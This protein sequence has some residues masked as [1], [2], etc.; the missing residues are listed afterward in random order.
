MPKLDFVLTWDWEY[1]SWFVNRFA[2]ACQVAAVDSLFVGP[3]NLKQVL[4]RIN[5]QE[6]RFRVLLDRASDTEEAFDPLIDQIVLS[7]TTNLNK[8]SHAVKAMDKA[9]M[10]L[11][12]LSGGIDVPHTVIISDKDNLSEFRTLE[13]EKLGIP[14]IVK[15]ATGGGGL[16]VCAVIRLEQIAAAREEFAD[17]KYLVQE[18]I[19]PTLLGNKRAYFRVYY[20]CGQVIP[21][22]WDNETRIFGQI[23][24]AEEE[25]K[26][27][28]GKLRTITAKIAGICKLDF[29]S[30]EICQM[31]NGRFVVVDYVNDPCDMRPRSSCPDGVPE[32]I[33]DLVIKHIIDYI[34]EVA[35]RELAPLQK[36]LLRCQREFELQLL[37]Q[38]R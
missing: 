32:E 6:I 7:G 23:L 30:T 21:C 37:R 36:E 26:F 28:L 17:E 35:W 12:F 13:I 8:M 10:H 1:D 15:P 34:K 27:A 33:I 29:F 14:F 24:D 9:T 31:P 19:V 25:E 18:K 38:H 3:T 4:Q 16:G 22:W 20:V 2:A 5:N 11:E